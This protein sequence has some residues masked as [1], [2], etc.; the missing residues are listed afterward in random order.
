MIAESES[1]HDEEARAVLDWEGRRAVGPHVRLGWLLPI[2]A[3]PQ[4][5]LNK[6]ACRLVK[7]IR[8]SLI[9]SCPSCAAVLDDDCPYNL[10][11]TGMLNAWCLL[12]CSYRLFW[13]S[14]ALSIPLQITTK[15]NQSMPQVCFLNVSAITF[16][17]MSSGAH[18]STS[19]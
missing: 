10:A 17:A 8:L 9:L 11:K 3:K 6:A 13:V 14:K 18:I 5:A 2:H 7:H 16:N 15:G 19:Q 12:Q 4:T 1:V